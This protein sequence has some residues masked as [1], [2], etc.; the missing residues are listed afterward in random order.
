M[1]PGERFNSYSHLVGLA[2]CLG[3]A[4]VLLARVAPMGDAARAAGALVFALCAVALYAASTLFH[5]TRGRAKRFWQRADHCS[6]F[7]LIAGSFTPFALAAA[8]DGWDLLPLALIWAVAALAIV[9]ELRATRGSPPSLA[10][11]VTMGWLAVLAAAPLAA[12]MQGPG[13][14]CLMIGAALYTA[15]TLFYR[16]PF[17]WRHAHGMWHLFVLGGTASHFVAVT[18]Y[19]L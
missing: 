9:R 19:V 6:V 2:L 13:L 4:A 12:R 18:W 8:R 3:G 10:V 16:N 7:L 17:G 14:A 1:Y 11:Y 15:G 5:S